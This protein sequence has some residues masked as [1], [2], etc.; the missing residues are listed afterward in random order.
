ASSRWLTKNWPLENICSFC[1]EL[2]RKEIRVVLT[3]TQADAGRAAELM[4]LCK[5]AKPINACAKT[6]INQLACLIKKCSVYISADSA[7][8]HVAAA[9]N[10]PI[11]ALFGPTDPARHMPQVKGAIVIRKD[12]DCSPCYKSKCKTVKCMSL[13]TAGEVLEAVNKLLNVK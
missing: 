3:G 7:P 1:E 5:T 9:S 4:S 8:L 11:V 6:T 13:I 2:S 10:V 12:L